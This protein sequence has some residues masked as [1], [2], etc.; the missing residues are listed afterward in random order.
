MNTTFVLDCVLFDVKYQILAKVPSQDVF[1]K[2]IAASTFVT[3]LII[4]TI[5]LNGVAVVTIMKCP[6]LKEKN[7]YF[8]IMVQSLADLATGFVTLPFFSY[9]CITQ[10][11][12]TADCFRQR[13]IMSM[14]SIPFS[15]SLTTLAVMTIDRY[16]SVLHPLKHRVMVTKRKLKT[17]LV[18]ASLF[19]TVFVVLS[20]LNTQ[21]LEG[22][23]SI[24]IFLF[25]L[26][27]IFVYTKIF[28]AIRTR[29][30]PGNV[31]D[32][33]A[34]N[35]NERKFAK[36]IKLVKS[37]FLAVACFLLCFLAGTLVLLFQRQVDR[38]EFIALKIFSGSLILLS[39]SLNSVVFFWTR[40]LLR[41]EA[42]K[43]V[44]KMC[45]SRT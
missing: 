33:A 40:P 24:Y 14:T 18:S 32:T 37:C 15:I 25:L 12:G 20:L 3:I 28:I 7:A 10:A 45:T 27:A 2:L 1:N 4:P 41:N 11:L 13:L 42:F 16:M 19:I 6:Q 30:S 43:V 17:F 35:Q 39:S 22:F 21:L 29:K 31:Q 5:L 38:A 34:K 44:K 8:L 26:L 23:H 9:V 36:E